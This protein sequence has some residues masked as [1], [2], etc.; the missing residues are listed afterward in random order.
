MRISA[1]SLSL[2][3]S[4]W[5]KCAQNGL[6]Y[7]PVTALSSS[8][9]PRP[10][11]H[12]ARGPWTSCCYSNATP[13]YACLRS[14]AILMT[15]K[16]F[17]WASHIVLSLLYSCLC[18]LLKPLTTLWNSSCS[19]LLT[20]LPDFILYVY[21]LPHLLE[22]LLPEDNNFV[23]ITG[24]PWC[25]AQNRC[26]INVC[27]GSEF[28]NDRIQLAQ[29]LQLAKNTTLFFSVFVE[30]QSLTSALLGPSRN[31]RVQNILRVSTVWLFI[32][33]LTFYN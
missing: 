24:V 30:A 28:V 21:Y 5:R 2:L 31:P 16:V 32:C 19:T 26:S 11:T 9:I 4:V 23:S 1:F 12:S 25:L 6:L 15:W 33:L 7:A 18:P 3:T 29:R 17:F 14:S 27:W 10:L 20:L 22:S 13:T 8:P